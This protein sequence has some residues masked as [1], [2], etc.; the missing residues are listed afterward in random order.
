MLTLTPADEAFR[1]E[2]RAWL[3]AN[4]A[5][6]AD[7]HEWHRRL[8]AGRWAVP[9]WPARWGGRDATLAQQIVHAQLMADFDAPVPRNSIGLFNIGPM[10]MAFGTPEQQARYLP[11]MV[12]ATEIWC[13]GFSEPGAGSDLAALRLRAEDH[14]DHW[15]VNGQ[16]TWTTFG[17]EADL[18]LALCRTDPDAPRHRGISALIVDMHAP[19]VE[20]RP[21]RDL[22]GEAGFNELYFTDVAVARD[23][24][25]G[26]LHGGWKVAMS[27]LAFERL[28]TMKL[29]VQLRKRLEQLTG[30]AVALRRDGDPLVRHRLAD[31]GVQVDLMQL[32]TEQAI[33]ALAAGADPGAAL[34]L[35]KLQWSLLMQHLA[36]A[37]VDLQGPAAQLARGSAHEVEGDWQHH[38]LYARMTTIG[39]GT[40]EVQRNIIAYRVLGLPRDVGEPSAPGLVARD[41]ALPDEVAALR[42][43]TRRF[44]A[45]RCDTAW[46]RGRLDDARGTTDEVWAGLAGLGLHA[47]FAPAAHGGLGLGYGELG[48]VLEEL[49]RAV[50]PGP[51]TS[52]ALQAVTAVLQVGGDDEHAALLP[53]LADGSVVGTLA[54]LERSGDWDWR[55]VATQAKRDGD[56]W[57]LDGTKLFVPDGAAADLLLVTAE[58]DGELALFAVE[59][60][61][62]GVAVTPLRTI[63]QT[64]RQAEVVLTGAAGRRLGAGDA[65]AALG[66]TLDRI[67][68]GLVAETVGAAHTALVLATEYAKVREQFDRP[69]GAFQAVQHLLAEMLRRVEL[70]RAG[71]GAALRAADAGDDAACHRAA[72]AAKAFASEGLVRATADAIQVFGGIGFTWEH[73]VHLYYRRALAL[74]HAFGGTAE[75]LDAY[76]RLLLP[77]APTGGAAG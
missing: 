75:H 57:R 25:V 11:P 55:R 51:F 27:T 68:A 3:E 67:V 19:G 59:A 22:T 37:A 32:L 18:C 66:R 8:V 10:L 20:V 33:A 12:T 72:V 47:V 31:L 5:A 36:E 61:D 71:A 44:L 13:Q 24:L 29:G 34:P 15:V 52:S 2:L 17:A 9:S 70:A 39:A 21:L 46:V 43:T 73:D 65:T 76:A 53:G 64:R 26:P 60:G 4:I 56:R 14:G 30:L 74:Q 58:A 49:G 35:G 50:H 41:P 77:A 38:V 1:D 62:A 23:A 54:L 6:A 42:A 45:Q 69:I 7:E 48:V 63:D 28:G 40:T 16:K